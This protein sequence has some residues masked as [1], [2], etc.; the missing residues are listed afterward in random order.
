[1][2][3]RGVKHGFRLAVHAIGDEANRRTLAALAALDPSP[4]PGS[5]IE[6]AQL[7]LDEDLSTFKKLGIVAS[8]QPEH[9]LDDIELCQ[10][11]WPGMTD[12]AFPYRSLVDA[13]A[14]IRLGSDCPVAPLE[15]WGAMA[16]A[17]SRE[18]AGTEGMGGWHP[19]QRLTNAEAWQ[20]STWNNK[21]SVEV[22]YRI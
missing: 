17:V 8:I 10:R 2:L 15:P 11:F 1:M 21:T 9:L 7:L 5:S 13:G 12:R 22:R 20:A 18:R 19:E 14:K 3:E 4:L 16:A 6:H